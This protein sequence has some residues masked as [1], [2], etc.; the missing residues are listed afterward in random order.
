MYLP[1]AHVRRTDRDG[2]LY[3]DDDGDSFRLSRPISWLMMVI[4]KVMLIAVA[5][6]NIFDGGWYS[7]LFTFSERKCLSSCQEC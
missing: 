2:M 6:L 4:L 3:D 5:V 1:R 7:I